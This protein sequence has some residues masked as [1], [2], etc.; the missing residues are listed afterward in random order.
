MVQTPVGPGCIACMQWQSAHREIVLLR[1][2]CLSA[3]IRRMHA[4]CLY[5]AEC[6]HC[7]QAACRQAGCVMRGAAHYWGLVILSL[8]GRLIQSWN[9]HRGSFPVMTGISE[10]MMPRPA[11]IHCKQQQG[12][13]AG[14]HFGMCR[15]GGK[16][17]NARCVSPCI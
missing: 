6:M 15:A 17:D 16:P 9:P 2:P 1:M 5:A 4:R 8:A 3:V 7:L 11:V 14:T 12:K 13:S 10:C